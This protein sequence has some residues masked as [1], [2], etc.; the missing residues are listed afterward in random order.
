[1]LFDW[2]AVAAGDFALQLTDQI[3]FGASGENRGFA[4][5]QAS[6]GYL[7]LNVAAF[8]S[9]SGRKLFVFSG[10][11]DSPLMKC[12]VLNEVEPLEITGRLNGHFVQDLGW[13][14]H[15]S[16]AAPTATQTR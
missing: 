9:L 6:P 8:Y 2:P 3:D 1:M 4:I 14:V 13:L 16:S 5:A 7:N 10:Q 15:D 12:S 11:G